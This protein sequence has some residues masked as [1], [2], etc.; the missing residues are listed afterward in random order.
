MHSKAKRASTVITLKDRATAVRLA[1]FLFYIDFFS[2]RYPCVTT[3]I[4][5]LFSYLR[6]DIPCYLVSLSC[7]FIDRLT[8]DRT[9]SLFVTEKGFGWSSFRFEKFGTDVVC[10]VENT[11]PNQVIVIPPF[12]H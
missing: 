11:F 7:L 3:F 10:S 2:H 12:V 1:Y 4:F 5:L 8:V 6:W 9:I